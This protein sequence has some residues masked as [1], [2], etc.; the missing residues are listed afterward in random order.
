MI[1]QLLIALFILVSGGTFS[2]EENDYAHIIRF[3]G[4]YKI[5]KDCSMLITERINVYADGNM[6][7]HGIYR[8]IPLTYDYEGG[9]TSVDFSI[10][11]LTRD[12]EKEDYHTETMDNGIRIYFGNKNISLDPGKYTYKLSYKVNHVLRFLKKSDELYWNTNG[13]GWVFTIDTLTARVLLPSGI[14]F[15]KF[16]GY[17]GSQGDA[18]SNYTVEQVNPNEILFKTKEPLSSYEGLTFAAS[19]DKNQLVYPT[20]TENFIYWIKSH[21][22]WVLLIFMVFFLILRNTLL[23]SKYGRDPKPGTIMPQYDAPE[24]FSPADVSAVMKRG[25]VD[26]IAFTGQIASLGVKGWIKIK[27]ENVQGATKFTFTKTEDPKQDLSSAENQVFQA[28]FTNK[29]SFSFF[30][31][32]YNASL[33]KGMDDLETNIQNRH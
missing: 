22:L 8:D 3:D 23:W 7:N 33:K 27:Q 18:G 13:N 1:R 25:K 12:G 32:T 11:S 30:E 6:I 5:N 21:A 20:A 17:T 19:W 10:V 24:G 9:Q 26:S 31:N 28:L 2:Q 29:D 16:I 14:Q 4:T 15:K